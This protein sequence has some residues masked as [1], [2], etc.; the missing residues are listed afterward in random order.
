MITEVKN[1]TG[2]K[3]A[4]RNVGS[5]ERTFEEF[6]ESF[7]AVVVSLVHIE[8]KGYNAQLRL[9]V[10]A[11]GK[12]YKVSQWDACEVGEEVMINS[13]EFTIKQEGKP[14]LI[15]YYLVADTISAPTQ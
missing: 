7:K 11:G 12:K 15:R 14:D 6:L 4:A 9:C 2:E 10:E 13:K 1:V 3:I 8:P 5:F